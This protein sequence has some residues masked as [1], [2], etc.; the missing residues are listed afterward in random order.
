MTIK[1]LRLLQERADSMDDD[2]TLADL[3]DAIEAVEDSGYG[4]ADDDGEPGC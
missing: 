1:Y 3:N 4:F 2:I